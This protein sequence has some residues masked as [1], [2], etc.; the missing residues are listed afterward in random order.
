MLKMRS[1]M[2]LLL[3][4]ILLA[5]PSV[6]KALDV[7]VSPAS[8]QQGDTISVVIT[9][10]TTDEAPT[11]ALDGKNYPAF[12]TSEGYRALVPTSPLDG[13]GQ[14]TL[15]VRGEGK[16]R[17]LGVW[18]KNRSFPTQRIT[19][20]GKASRPATKLELDRVAE[21]KK[22]V[23]PTKYWDGSFVRPNGSRV[24]TVYGVRR[25]YNGVFANNYYHKGVDYAGGFGSSIVAPA[26]GKVVLIGKEA[27]GFHVHGN[28]V[29][30]DHGQGLISLFL[31]LQDIDVKEGDTIQ[32][33][34]RVG[35]VGSTGA[36][37]GPHLHWGLYLHGVAV[38]PVPWRFT[39]ID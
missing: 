35:T 30:L 7:E 32:A 21:V 13:S 14:M 38:D 22:L 19:L 10:T 28:I 12:P 24:S 23:T 17:N 1:Q 15:Q 8:P 25:Y 5:F 18:L 34:Q 2:R 29:G 11:V 31:H 33:G 39:S 3:T 27:E 20:S 9:G 37:T 36:S 4:A 16:T 26:A 6:A